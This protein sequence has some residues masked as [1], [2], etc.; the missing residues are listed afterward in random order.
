LDVTE[1][2]IS[3]PNLKMVCANNLSGKI[4]K[5]KKI[6][7]VLYLILIVMICF[8]NQIKGAF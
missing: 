2:P 6:I 8:K 7:K 1:I 3:G 5:K 4:V